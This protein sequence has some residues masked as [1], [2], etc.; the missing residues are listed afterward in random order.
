[1]GTIHQLRSSIFYVLK[2]NKDGSFATQSNRKKMLFLCAEEIVKHGYKLKH[3]KG[4]KQKHIQSLVHK[5]KINELSIGTIKN[6]LASIRWLCEKINRKNIVPSNDVLSVGPRKFISNQ[7]KAIVLDAEKLRTIE[8]QHIKL[9]L[10][11]QHHFG[12]R[13]EEALKIKPFIA[14]KNKYL[15]LEGSWCK[16]GRP[17]RIPILANEQRE[18]LDRCKSFISSQYC[19]MIPK[20]KTYRQHLKVYENQLRK[21][22][23]SKA[24]GLRHAYAQQRYRELTGWDC[25]A[26]DGPTSKSLTDDKKLLDQEARLIISEEMGHSRPQIVSIYI[27]RGNKND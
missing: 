16:N 3:I 12:L 2:H 22:G 15:E 23:I 4:L 7:N 5:W 8:S 20:D 10:Q 26:K 11:L 14:D 9:S 21:A 24:H 6:R 27:N 25:P 1:M 18:L 19:S 17:R 13:R